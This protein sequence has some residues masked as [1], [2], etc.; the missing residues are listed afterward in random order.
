MS[1][2]QYLDK[3]D[4]T[5]KP[6]FDNQFNKTYFNNLIDKL[7][8]EYDNYHILPKKDQVF[9]VFQLPIDQIKIVIIGQDPYPTPGHPNGLA[10]S[11]NEDVI[12]LPK[13]LKNIYK[14]IK[15]EYTDFNKSNGDLISWFYQGVFLINTILSIRSKE[16]LSHKDIGWNTFTDNLLSYLRENTH[17]LVFMLWG[18]NS[19]N[20]ESKIDTSKNIVI[21]TSHPSPLGYSKTGTYFKSFKDSNQFIEA[22]NYL[23]SVNKTEIDW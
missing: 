23:K 6:F 10:F 11:V 5:W 21:K 14:E 17:N 22:N 8:Y 1:L 7:D 2:F 15:K 4:T 12:P 16:I 3:I 19:H 13:S 20:F 18:K 9:R